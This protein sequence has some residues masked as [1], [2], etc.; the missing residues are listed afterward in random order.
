MRS[1]D[2]KII[3]DM[4]IHMKH[5]EA[6]GE[7]PFEGFFCGNWVRNPISTAK[8]SNNNNVLYILW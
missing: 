2:I 6:V 7:F 1:G 4:G 8:P 3:R 5:E